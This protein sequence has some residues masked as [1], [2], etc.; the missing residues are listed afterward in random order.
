[1]GREKLISAV[2]R[3]IAVGLAIT[4]VFASL[5]G[6][7]GSSSAPTTVPAPSFVGMNY[8]P[9]QFP[10]DPVDNPIQLPNGT[11]RDIVTIG[12]VAPLPNVPTFKG[13]L[14]IKDGQAPLTY[15]ATGQIPRGMGLE[16]ATGKITYLAPDCSEQ[17]QLKTVTYT[18]VDTQN[19]RT[20]PNLT[21]TYSVR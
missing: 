17:G 10:S 7:G 12:C 21:V 13:Q 3:R 14:V 9:R 19:Q 15:Q 16:S 5:V 20:N 4:A 18:V 11:A 1:M 6:C 2:T 8:D